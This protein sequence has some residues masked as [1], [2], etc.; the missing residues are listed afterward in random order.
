MK[1]C[2]GNAIAGSTA[3]FSVYLLDVEELGK[4][5]VYRQIEQ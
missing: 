2:S 3:F 5:M 1:E 4:E